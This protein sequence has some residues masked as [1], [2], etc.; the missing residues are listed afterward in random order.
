MDYKYII[1]LVARYFEGLTTLEEEE[2]L[3]TFFSQ[4]DVPAELMC[5]QDLFVYMQ[6]EPREDVLGPEFDERMTALTEEPVRVKA[7]VIPMSRRLRPLFKAAAVVAIVLTVGNAA[8]VPFNDKTADP[9]NIASGYETVQHGTSV[10][11]TDSAVI[12][13]IKQSQVM[14]MKQTDEDLLQT[15]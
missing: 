1:Q 12:D 11:L 6:N 4:K 14:P 10:A 7:R 9:A 5:Y 13:T 8:Q 2:I 15:R 3:R